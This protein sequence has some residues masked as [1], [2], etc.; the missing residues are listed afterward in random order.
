M[1]LNKERPRPEIIA[2]MVAAGERIHELT[3]THR[4]EEWL[5]LA[6][7]WLSLDLTMHQ[8]HVLLL[9]GREG[10]ANMARLA[11]LLGVKLPTITGLVDRLVERGLVRREESLHDRRLVLARLTDT[12]QAM[13]DRLSEAG[14]LW[15]ERI[16]KRVSIEDLETMAHALEILRQAVESEYG[17]AD[18]GAEWSAGTDS[19]SR[20]TGAR[21]I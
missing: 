21:V 17:L 13:M 4:T 9:L 3:H 15:L 14:R 5:S 2:Q 7:E 18:R 10:E 12:G 6:E 8:M 11:Q 1:S 19:I 16:L 20:V